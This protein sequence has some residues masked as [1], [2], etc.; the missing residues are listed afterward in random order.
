MP[1]AFP[2]RLILAAFPLLIVGCATK[3]SDYLK[4]VSVDISGLHL[5]KKSD[6][7]KP[8]KTT[9]TPGPFPDDFPPSRVIVFQD[10]RPYEIFASG[11]FIYAFPAWNVV[12]FYDLSGISRHRTISDDLC[13]LKEALREQRDARAL[14]KPYT[15]LPDYPP[16]NAGHLVQENVHY[17]DFPWGKGVFYLCAFTQ[18]PGNFPNNDELIYLFQG[19]SNDHRLYVSADFRVKSRLISQT[20]APSIEEASS[21][22]D[23]ATDALAQK[24]NDE[25]DSAFSPNLATIRNWMK[26]IKLPEK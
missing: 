12:R 10:R 1:T 20:K 4:K 19:L 25:P 2:V 6:E 23:R 11:K 17:V 14:K 24:L 22:I 3:D 21:T 15:S 9:A 7:I 13:H 26:N 8:G 18:G 5:E 16:R